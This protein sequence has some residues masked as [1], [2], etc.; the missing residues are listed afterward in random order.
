[1]GD[2]LE[3]HLA[4]VAVY[5]K[6]RECGLVLNVGMC[7]KHLAYKCRGSQEANCA[8]AVYLQH[9]LAIMFSFQSKNSA[10]LCSWRK[11]V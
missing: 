7:E 9:S 6:K 11:W 2:N 3:D 1:M 8:V 10:D 4:G 5:V